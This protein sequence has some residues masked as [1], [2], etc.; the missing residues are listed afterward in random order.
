MIWG[1]LGG[2]GLILVIFFVAKKAGKDAVKAQIGEQNIQ[3]AG[4]VADAVAK[5]PSSRDDLLER[6]RNA[7]RNL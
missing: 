7:E 6:L 2:L 4:R 1:L 3:A 5:G